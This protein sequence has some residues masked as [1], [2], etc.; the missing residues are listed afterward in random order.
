MVRKKRT[1]ARKTSEFDRFDS[2]SDD[3]LQHILSKLSAKSFARS[4]CV[5]RSWRRICNAI[6]FKPKLCCAISLEPIT[7]VAVE[8]VVEKV[9]SQPIKPQF[10]I[11]CF[12][13]HYNLETVHHLVKGKFG[14][15]VPVVTNLVEGVIGVE[16][17]RNMFF[18][19]TAEDVESYM[20]NQEEEL[21]DD[22]ELPV[23]GVALIVGW[24]P[25]MKV[26]AI[27]LIRSLDK[28]PVRSR[29]SRFSRDI[30]NYAKSVSDLPP[31]A[32]ILFGDGDAAFSKRLFRMFD[33]VFNEETAI[34]GHVNGFFLHR[35]S[36]ASRNVESNDERCCE[37]IALVFAR[38]MNKPSGVGETRFHVPCM[39]CVTRVGPTFSVASVR[40]NN[41]KSFI[42]GTTRE[43]CGR[44]GGSKILSLIHEMDE[45]SWFEELYVGV[46]KQEAAGSSSS[47]AS[48][49]LHALKMDSCQDRL[50]VEG[51]GISIGDSFS[52]Y[53]PDFTRGLTLRRDGGE[54]SK[55]RKEVFGGVVFVAPFEFA[56]GLSREDN[57]Y[58]HPFLEQFPEVA[59]GGMFSKKVVK[60]GSIGSALKDDDA[61]DGNGD[62]ESYKYCNPTKCHK[63]YKGTSFLI[64]S[65]SPP[66]ATSS[67]G[68]S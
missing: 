44:L 66:P 24:L 25:D 58:S 65:Y 55:I 1:S 27:P 61:D 4:A 39:T 68:N 41:S 26:E 64:M 2:T 9:L 53:R 45:R 57:E 59:L 13:M 47:S 16:T 49:S 29:L 36:E 28:E 22:D 56:H 50:V 30:K 43:N 35:S 42:L 11:A 10:V 21:Y 51:T 19:A 15:T 12:T 60:H 33:D 7:E 20:M 6:L 37:A 38:N 52:L 54:Q 48:M 34:V 3:I 40:E 18:E 32:V 31:A 8:E 23:L 46:E 62:Y 14:S 63:T 67:H 5:S 17:Q